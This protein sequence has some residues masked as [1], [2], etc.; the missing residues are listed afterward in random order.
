MSSNICLDPSF[1]SPS[2]F[3]TAAVGIWPGLP[4]NG[5]FVTED[6]RMHLHVFR[7]RSGCPRRTKDTFSRSRSPPRMFRNP[8]TP[9]TGTKEEDDEALHQVR[10]LY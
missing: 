10:D 6:H 3:L 2:P 1:D 4:D 8:A 7:E 9:A 5:K